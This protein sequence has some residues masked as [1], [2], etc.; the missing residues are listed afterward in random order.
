MADQSQEQQQ[1]LEQLKQ[2]QG[3]SFVADTETRKRE[4]I[5]PAQG[6]EFRIINS[7]LGR[8]SQ[9][10]VPQMTF[11]CQVVSHPEGE[12]YIGKS[13]YQ[14]FTLNSEKG[15]GWLKAFFENLE[16]GSPADFDEIV[17]LGDEAVEQGVCFVA[18]LV[19]N[20]QDPEQ[21]AP[22]MFV[23]RGARQ[24]NLEGGE[25]AAF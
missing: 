24:R 17:K 1:I 14:N 13:Y 15:M 7:F 2:E 6:V 16:L 20:Q 8:S 10:G 22:N 18:N 5:A 3:D 9:K 21:Y 23:N 25:G 12:K 19:P 4:Q 11:V